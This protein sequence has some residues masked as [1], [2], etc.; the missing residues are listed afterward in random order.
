MC[1]LQVKDVEVELNSKWTMFHAIQ[2]LGKLID[3]GN[4][5]KKSTQI[6]KPTYT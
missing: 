4:Y 5:E 1:F 3:F 6:W 2:K